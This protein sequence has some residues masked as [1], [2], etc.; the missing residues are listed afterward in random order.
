MALELED[1]HALL[2]REDCTNKDS[3]LA[4][5]SAE[6]NNRWSPNTPSGSDTTS[7]KRSFLH[8]RIPKYSTKIWGT[9]LIVCLAGILGLVVGLLVGRALHRG[10]GCQEVATTVSPTSSPQVPLY[11]DYGNEV[12]INGQAVVVT[13]VFVSEIK[14]EY[15]H[16]YL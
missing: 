11:E 8:F 3:F 14:T 5:P 7:S 2:D 4:K 9:V 13:D 10:D 6:K 12:V 15:L 16:N 1:Q